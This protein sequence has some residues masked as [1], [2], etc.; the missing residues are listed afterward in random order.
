[1]QLPLP[2]FRR[3]PDPEL[4]EGEGPPHWPLQLLL[5]LPLPLLLPLLL[6]LPLPL[7]VFRR[8]PAPEIAEGEGPPHWPPLLW[9]SSLVPHL[10]RFKTPPRDAAAFNSG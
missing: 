3:H 5:Q 2:V 1:L 10:F 9:Q 4:A 6:L 8:H 7:P